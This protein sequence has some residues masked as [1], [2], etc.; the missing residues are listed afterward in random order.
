MHAEW[1]GVGWVGRLLEGVQYL[2]TTFTYGNTARTTANSP[3]LVPRPGL[4]SRTAP[5]STALQQL[6]GASDSQ[7]QHLRSAQARAAALLRFEGGLMSDPRAGATSASN[8]AARLRLLLTDRDFDGNDYDQLLALDNNNVRTTP[9][10]TETDI[11][12][13]PTHVL[14]EADLARSKVSQARSRDCW[15]A[16]SVRARGRRRAGTVLA[17]ATAPHTRTYPHAATHHSTPNIEYR[18][19]R[20]RP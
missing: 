12:R 3:D 17:T 5:P 10:A 18:P 19:L 7:R 6:I 1:N 11:R 14:T 8:L 20:P 16:R 15:C 9:V 4:T 13:L 2:P